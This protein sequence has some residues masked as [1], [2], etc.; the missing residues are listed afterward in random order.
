M[1]DSHNSRL[2]SVAASVCSVS[3]RGCVSP[4]RCDTLARVID[5]GHASELTAMTLPR[6]AAGI[7]GGQPRPCP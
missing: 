6:K 5:G 1:A 3:A 4:Q 2:L 7:P